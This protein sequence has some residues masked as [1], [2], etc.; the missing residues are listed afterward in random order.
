MLRR[1][2][3]MTGRLIE[4]ATMQPGFTLDEEPSRLGRG[5]VSYV[6][7]GLVRTTAARCRV[8]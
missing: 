3:S 6:A 4:I 8:D 2:C 7:A 1:S 5:L